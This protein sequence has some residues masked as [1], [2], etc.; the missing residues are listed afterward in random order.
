M[1]DKIRHDSSSARHFQLFSQQKQNKSNP[2]PYVPNSKWLELYVNGILSYQAF[3]LVNRGSFSK[4]G[5]WA[6]AC[7]L[8]L[9][10]YHISEVNCMWPWIWQIG[11][12]F[13]PQRDLLCYVFLEFQWTST[14]PAL[15]KKNRDSCFIVT[16]TNSTSRT[17]SMRAS[18]RSVLEHFRLVT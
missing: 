13:Y 18:T 9:C 7:L 15:L 2:L 16:S 6:F 1:V 5:I 3:W 12:P 11:S 8:C 4:C 17:S 14:L 10:F